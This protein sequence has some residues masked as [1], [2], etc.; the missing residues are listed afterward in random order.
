M[1]SAQS[2]QRNAYTCILQNIFLCVSTQT[3]RWLEDVY[4]KCLKKIRSKLKAE[5]YCGFSQHCN[6]LLGTKHY[7]IFTHTFLT[8]ADILRAVQSNTCIC[9]FFSMA[10]QPLG[11]LGRIIFRGFTITLFRHTTLGRTPLDEGP[12]PRRDLCLTTHNT[13]NRQTSMP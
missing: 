13:H 3:L 7:N 2:R 11:G 10:R 1:A 6:G 9:L 5:V 8:W 4:R 12:A